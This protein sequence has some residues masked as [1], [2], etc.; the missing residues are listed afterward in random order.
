MGTVAFVV[1][2]INSNDNQ[3]TETLLVLRYIDVPI[4][5]YLFAVVVFFVC[6]CLFTAK[7][8]RVLSGK[9]F[10]FEVDM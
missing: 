5:I 10:S 8:F 4:S 7:D 9:S 3:E 1:L 2:L 6:E